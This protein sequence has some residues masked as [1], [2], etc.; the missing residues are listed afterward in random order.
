MVWSETRESDN[1]NF[2]IEK[3]IPIKII[4]EANTCDHWTKKSARH[5]KQKAVI[6]LSLR[7]VISEVSLPC[8]V[9]LTRIAPRFLDEHDNLRSSLKWVVDSIASLLFPNLK[10]GRAD[11]DKR[12]T[13]LYAQDK[14]GI[15]QYALKVVIIE[16]SEMDIM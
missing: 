5:K 9:Q 10:P 11:D 6:Q 2:M 7:P 15:R 4:S 8:I 3:I 13:W 12:I 1:I 16:K 14:G